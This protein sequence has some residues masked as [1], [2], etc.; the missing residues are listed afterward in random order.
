[1]N[2]QLIKTVRYSEFLEQSEITSSRRF[3]LQLAMAGLHSELCK[4]D[5]SNLRKFMNHGVAGHLHAYAVGEDLRDPLHEHF[6]DC[7]RRALMLFDTE[8]HDFRDWNDRAQHMLEDMM[9]LYIPGA[10]TTYAALQIMRGEYEKSQPVPY[11][12]PEEVQ[13]LSL[14][15]YLGKNFDI[16]RRYDDAAGVTYVYLHDVHEFD[17]SVLETLLS[18]PEFQGLEEPIEDDT[19]TVVRIAGEL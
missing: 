14:I 4:L 12:E 7:C 8:E 6:M 16:S 18:Y 13:R 19:C 5:L 11:G 15:K 2:A 1:M 17:R 10:N 9:E 3:G